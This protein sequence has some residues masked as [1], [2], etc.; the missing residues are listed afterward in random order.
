MMSLP[1][2]LGANVEARDLNDGA[3]HHPSGSPLGSDGS[4]HSG[5]GIQIHVGSTPD[6]RGQGRALL[7]G[8]G[9]PPQKPKDPLPLDEDIANGGGLY[10]GAASAGTHLFYY[11]KSI[12]QINNATP[13]LPL[14]PKP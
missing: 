11:I 7:N 3:D 2:L 12:T 8:K 13:P 9:A 14:N 1:R 5:G 4:L 6:S 10:V